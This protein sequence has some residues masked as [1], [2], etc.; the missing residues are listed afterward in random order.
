MSQKALLNYAHISSN[1]KTVMHVWMNNRSKTV[2]EMF[3]S[4]SII[5]K[6]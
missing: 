1:K 2:Q 6:S 4:H 5:Q 3:A